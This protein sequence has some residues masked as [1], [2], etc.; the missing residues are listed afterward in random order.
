M[1]ILDAEKYM[2][3]LRFVLNSVC[4]GGAAIFKGLETENILAQGWHI[5]THATYYRL[6]HEQAVLQFR[7][8]LC[9]N[10]HDYK[11]MITFF[12]M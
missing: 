1:K 5:T 7:F 9:T 3:K 11:K 4:A 8:W 6:Q 10:K 12:N 2:W